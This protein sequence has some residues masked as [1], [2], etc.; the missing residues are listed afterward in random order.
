ML[1]HQP[2]A[3]FLSAILLCLMLLRSGKESSAVTPIQPAGY[4]DSISSRRPYLRGPP[5]DAVSSVVI[6]SGIRAWIPAVV[7]AARGDCRPVKER[8]EGVRRLLG[9]SRVTTRWRGGLASAMATLAWAIH[10]CSTICDWQWPSRFQRSDNGRI[11]L[12]F[13]GRSYNRVC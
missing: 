6:V 8:F 13:C 1:L 7:E 11:E 2:T 9:L 10:V 3:V 4:V 5:V 12:S